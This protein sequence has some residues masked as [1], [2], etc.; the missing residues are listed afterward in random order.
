MDFHYILNPPRSVT[1]AKCLYLHDSYI[2]IFDSNN[3]HFSTWKLCGCIMKSYMYCLSRWWSRLSLVSNVILSKTDILSK[4]AIYK[5]YLEVEV[6]G[7][8]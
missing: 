2:S 6:L 3:Y 5:L 1:V 4:I 8:D 7:L